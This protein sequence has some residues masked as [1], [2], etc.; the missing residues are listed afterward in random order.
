MAH[1]QADKLLA[2]LGLAKRAGRLAVGFRA[3]EKMVRHGE[4]PLVIIAT[5]VGASQRGKITRWEPVAG[6]ITEVLHSDDMARTLG[7]DKLVV[8]G[9]SDSGFVRGI[10][11][12]D[13]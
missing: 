9:L 5:D 11:K 4:K 1:E 10:K 8:V 12:L 13:L 2:L 3:V 7:R 6:F